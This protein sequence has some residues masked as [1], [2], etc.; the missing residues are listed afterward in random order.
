MD[1]DL[2]QRYKGKH[3]LQN[4]LRNLKFPSL[5]GSLS[6]CWFLKFVTRTVSMMISLGLFHFLNSLFCTMLY[7]C[8]L[9]CFISFFFCLEKF[10]YIVLFPLLPS[11][12]CSFWSKEDS[13]SFSLSVILSLS[14]NK[15][16]FFVIK[17]KIA[18]RI[19]FNLT[20]GIL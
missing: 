6:M 10:C 14:M 13:L 5:H 3:S 8:T 2:G 11:F 1:T 18:F 9:I 7:T 15:I 12:F 4:G 19:N 20:C 17:N 16:Y